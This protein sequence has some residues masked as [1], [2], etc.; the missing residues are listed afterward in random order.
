[1]E[2]P[3]IRI[4]YFHERDRK[5]TYFLVNPQPLLKIDLT[6]GDADEKNDEVKALFW[7]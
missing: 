4:S 5:S 7:V 1:M 2:M 6:Q 3:G